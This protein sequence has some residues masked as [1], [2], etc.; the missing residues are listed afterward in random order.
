[1]RNIISLISITIFLSLSAFAGK[2]AS[3]PEASGISYCNKS[4]TLVIANDEGSFYEIS[5]NGTIIK[6]YKLGKYDLEGVVCEEKRFVF[7]IEKGALLEVN[8]KTL[9]SKKLKIK[10]GRGDN[11]KFSKKA[12]IEGI[13]KIDDLYYISLQTKKAKDSLLLVLKM[14]KNYL[15][16]VKRIKQRIADSSGMQ[17]YKKRLYIV[18]DKKDK[19]YIYNLKKGKIEKKIKLPKF[20]QEG[21]TFDNSGNI[22]FADDNGAIMKYKMDR[23]GL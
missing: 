5:P 19:L 8:R 15:K 1:M 20:A 2:I 10:D 22:Y 12:G 9:K 11:L 3:I 7:A 16:V 13:T 14:E 23:F 4:H 17:Y 21:V 6:Q 18:S